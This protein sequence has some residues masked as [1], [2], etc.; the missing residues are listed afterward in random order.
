MV[1]YLFS[2]SICSGIFLLT[3]Q[4]LLF[5]FINLFYDISLPLNEVKLYFIVIVTSTVDTEVIFGHKL[6]KI[7]GTIL[8]QERVCHLTEVLIF[9]NYLVKKCSQE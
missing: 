1:A 4:S 6:N 5:E 8:W 9:T 2:G 7:T 3:T